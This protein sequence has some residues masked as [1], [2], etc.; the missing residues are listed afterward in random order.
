MCLF[1]LAAEKEE[2]AGRL[3]SLQGER[4]GADSCSI[5]TRWALNQKNRGESTL[6]K[7]AQAT[8]WKVVKGWLYYG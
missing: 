6:F 7:S 1:S 5:L 2:L 4:E 8:S 3:P